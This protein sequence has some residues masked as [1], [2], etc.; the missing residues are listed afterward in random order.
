MILP[1]SECVDRKGPEQKKSWAKREEPLE[2]FL[3]REFAESKIRAL[4]LEPP[5][6]LKVPPPDL[7]HRMGRGQPQPRQEVL[8]LASAITLNLREFMEPCW[9]STPRQLR[10]GTNSG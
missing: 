9:R 4:T 1:P 6:P 2:D 10:S 7:I 8:F 5:Q 3:G